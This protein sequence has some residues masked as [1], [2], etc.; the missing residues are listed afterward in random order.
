MRSTQCRIVLISYVFSFRSYASRDHGRRA[1][2]TLRVSQ[3]RD[4]EVFLRLRT[5]WSATARGSMLGVRRHLGGLLRLTAVT[6]R[7][8]SS[9]T[10]NVVCFC[11]VVWI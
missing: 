5:P 1:L 9:L 10:E 7:T 4:A 3:L 8:N 6:L 11:S 2:L